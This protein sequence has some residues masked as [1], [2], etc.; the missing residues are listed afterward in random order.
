MKSCF[1]KISSF[2]LYMYVLLGNYYLFLNT[3]YV[4]NM[5]MCKTILLLTVQFSRV[6][7]IY[8]IQQIVTTNLLFFNNSFLSP[9]LQSRI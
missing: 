4:L 6:C 9:R 7:F 8:T 3:H 1:I 2:V 5:L